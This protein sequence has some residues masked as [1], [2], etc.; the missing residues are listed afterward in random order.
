MK[1]PGQLVNIACMSTALAFAFA[2]AGDL[3]SARVQV[4]AG[5]MALAAARRRYCDQAGELPPVSGEERWHTD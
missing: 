3:P 1:N 5:Q 4:L 2:R